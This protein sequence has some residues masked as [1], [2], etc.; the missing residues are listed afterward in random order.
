MDQHRESSKSYGTSGEMGWGS[1]GGRSCPLSVVSG[2]SVTG[3]ARQP[4]SNDSYKLA[5]LENLG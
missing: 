4:T 2:F 5:V 3:K 1:G